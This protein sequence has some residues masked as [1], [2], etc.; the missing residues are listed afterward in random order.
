MQSQTHFR[1]L[2]ETVTG[3]VSQPEFVGTFSRIA[4]FPL[5]SA[6]EFGARKFLDE[7]ERECERDG[8][9]NR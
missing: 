5:R 6:I 9:P 2:S 7:L 4:S 1:L 8:A 3:V